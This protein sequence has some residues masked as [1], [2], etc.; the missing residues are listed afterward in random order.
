M[1]RTL[2]ATFLAWLVPG[3]GHVMLGR[4]LRGVI[5]FIIIGAMFWTGVGL[6][7]VMTECRG[8]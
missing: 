6:G 5:I 3:A 1:A 2:L 7:G 8:V 4:T